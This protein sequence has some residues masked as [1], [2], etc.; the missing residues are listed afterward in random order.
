MI[1][2]VIVFGI[3]VSVI[4]IFVSRL[5]WMLDNY[6]FFRVLIMLSFVFG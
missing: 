3:S 6:W 5:L 1:E 2:K 4:M